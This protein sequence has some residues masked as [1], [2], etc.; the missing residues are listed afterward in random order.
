MPG[1][2]PQLDRT[3]QSIFVFVESNTSGTG[4]LFLSK[5]TALD[6]KPVLITRDEARYRFAKNI[7]GL[8]VLSSDTSADAVLQTLSGVEW[9]SRIKGV[10]STSEYHVAVAAR[11]ARELGLPSGD[12]VAIAR[13]RNKKTQRDLIFASSPELCPN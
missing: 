11:V 7:P 4:E 1:P 2:W 13:S 10:I 3:E 8:A 12:P 5:A 6:L 9:R